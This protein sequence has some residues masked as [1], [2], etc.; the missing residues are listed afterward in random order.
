MCIN[1]VTKF[2]YLGNNCIRRQLILFSDTISKTSFESV[3]AGVN[4]I[5]RQMRS[6]G[7]T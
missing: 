6:K 5:P 4:L 3:V 7:S 1:K 2:G